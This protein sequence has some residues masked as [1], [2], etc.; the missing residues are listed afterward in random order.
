MIEKLDKMFTFSYLCLFIVILSFIYSFKNIIASSVLIIL[1]VLFLV[2]LSRHGYL[3]YRD[4]KKQNKNELYI[5]SY[6][7]KLRLNRKNLKKL[8]LLGISI[9]IIAIYTLLIYF[10]FQKETITNQLNFIS[11]IFMI[12]LYVWLILYL[13]NTDLSISLILFLTTIYALLIF[14]F[15]LSFVF[16]YILTFLHSFIDGSYTFNYDVVMKNWGNI[17]SDY[18]IILLYISKFKNI[19]FTSLFST[20]LLQVL[21]IFCVP[22][23]KFQ[24]NKNSFTVINYFFNGL[25]LVLIFVK[26]D[27]S[28]YIYNFLY[29][30]NET[31]LLD[32]LRETHIDKN[33]FEVLFEKLINF[34]LLPYIIGTFIGLL[35][36]QSKEE[37]NIKKA[38][39]ILK[40]IMENDFKENILKEKILDAI[41]YGGSQFEIIFRSNEKFSK[42]INELEE[43]TINFSLKGKLLNFKISILNI[44]KNINSKILM[45]KES[46]RVISK[47]LSTHFKELRVKI[48]FKLITLLVIN[49]LLINIGN[50]F[51]NQNE[52]IVVNF[53][54][55]IEYFFILLFFITLIFFYWLFISFIQKEKTN[56]RWGGI[57]QLI[58]LLIITKPLIIYFLLN[59]ISIF[60]TIKFK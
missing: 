18:I 7:N 20:I 45:F 44:L 41:F 10:Y 27:L 17:V 26:S 29:T 25:I 6:K 43:P 31:R 46:N 15:G 32:L 56:K 39:Q 47:F 38:N 30:F 49:Y 22:I 58:I 35:V 50:L 13:I 23:Y 16:I 48:L 36:I 57:L 52:N 3:I 60:P 42:F 8:L 2:F 5:N 19:F 54:R 37:K 59:L 28:E 53:Y 34:T 12:C 24:K 9:F 14:T 33:N 1:L 40:E 51:G 55:A 4:F 11:M 21:V